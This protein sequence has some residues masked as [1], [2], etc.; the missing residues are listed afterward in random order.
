[1][2]GKKMLLISDG[3]FIGV[4]LAEKLGKYNDLPIEEEK[5]IKGVSSLLCW[6]CV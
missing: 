6:Q 3:G 5:I 1:M 2:K 4:T